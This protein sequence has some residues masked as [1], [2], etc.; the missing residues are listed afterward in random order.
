VKLDERRW[1][2][3]GALFVFVA[4]QIIYLLTLTR[5][6]PFW[7][8]GE[9][10][11]TSYILGIPHPPGTPFYVLIGR[12]LSMLPI[13]TIATRVNYLSA[14]SSSIAA[15]FGYLVTVEF[16]SW[17]QRGRA[18]RIP[19][20]IGVLGG[21][22]AGLFT[23][24]SRTL[25]ENALEAEVYGLSSAA[26]MIAL[27]LVVRWAREEGATERD[28]RLFV[29]AY[30]LIAVSAGIHMGTFLVV[31][32][33]L[34]F[35]LLVDHRTL[36]PSRIGAI[37]VAG[38]LVGLQP[39]MLP[40][41][42]EGWLI[43]LG[44]GLLGSL[45]LG[46]LWSPLGPRG[47]VFWCLLL[48][49]VG[50]STHLYLPIR[51]H[52]HPIIN[53]ADPSTSG[54]LWLALIRDQ[55]KPSNPFLVR[56]ATLWVQLNKH[57]WRYAHDQY[58]LHF[59][60]AWLAAYLPYLIGVVGAVAHARREKKTFLTL[61]LFYLI[62]TVGMIFYLNFRDDEV[63]DRDYFFTM[64][65][66][67]FAVWIGLGFST[68]AG[69]A[70]WAYSEGRDRL[71]QNLGWG[72][73]LLGVVLAFSACGNFYHMRNRHGF[74]LARDLAYN[75]LMP[76]PKDAL[77]FTNGDND[78]FPLWYI[79]E[80]EN[81]RK[82]VRVLNL[83]LLNTDWYMEQLRDQQPK[84][85]LGWGDAEIEAVKSV[86]EVWSA[87][88]QQNISRD[89]Y[90]SFLKKY[91]IS[92]YVP[93]VD[94]FIYAKDLSSRRIIEREYG[95]RPIFF[96]VTVPDQMGFTNRLT[97][98][99]I[100][101]RLGEKHAGKEE[102]IDVD[103]TLHNLREVYLYRGLL[104]KDGTYDPSVY[105]DDNALRLVQNYAAGYVRAA[106]KLVEQG[107]KEDAVQVADAAKRMSSSGQVLYTCG[108]VYFQADRPDLAEEMFRQLV[109]RG[110]GEYAIV[111]LLGR[112]IERQGR[113]AEAE[114]VYRLGYE[115]YP[116]DQEA[117]RELFSFYVEQGRKA[118][119]IGTLDRWVRRHPG[120]EGA[121]KRLAEIRDS[122]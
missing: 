120:D 18:D 22:A 5:T 26:I 82:D 64:A 36:A 16:F 60:P 113:V 55:Y 25:W 53:E 59:R 56:N 98:E 46:R 96:A 118:D 109:E 17:Q 89:D 4:S 48:A 74:Y 12:I 49:L 73:A 66:Q 21:I 63:R 91:G 19:L 122:L 23:A 24:F 80:V 51:A 75:M 40:I 2:G 65:Y 43:L 84:V 13:G 11:S 102:D 93:N 114:Q 119:A 90:I 62:T 33:L 94:E 32:A 27:W 112:T 83:S 52:Q 31:P 108:I 101:F 117:L 8:S 45:F 106:E 76:L 97:M 110:Y 99:G 39:A 105:K 28:N 35:V 92:K 104:R 57:F 50:L 34:L 54:R 115:T 67:I 86:P 70:R 20:E 68:L 71:G 10:I 9:F 29:L 6:C 78:T 15:V 7:D 3:L 47:V 87:Y 58:Q 95:K 38:I 116:D 85:D 30:Y 121:R 37:V 79:Q 81:V 77:L 14:L 44:L 69:W 107:R 100:A 111:R 1:I 103:V 42:K 88:A 61:L 72:V 41:L